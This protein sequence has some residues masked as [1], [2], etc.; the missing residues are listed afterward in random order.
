MK[1]FVDWLRDHVDFNLKIEELSHLLTMCGLNC[2]GIEEHGDDHVLELEVTS[3]RPDHLGHRGVARELSCLLKV[4]LKPLDLDFDTVEATASGLALDEVASIVVDDEERCGRYTARVAEGLKISES[5]DWIRRRLEAIGLRPINL[6][7]DLTNYVLMD[8]GQPLHA[9]DL[10][11]LEGGEVIVRR[12]QRMEKSSAIDGSEHELDSED[13]VIA[14]QSGTAALAG[15][16][17]GTRTE[18]HE[19]NQ[20]ILLESAWFEP[21]PVRLSSRRLI[22]ASDSSYRFERRLDVEACE[23]ASRRFMHL[24]GPGVGLFNPLWLP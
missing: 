5:P 15:I 1:V 9:F 6:V 8:L 23:I 24:P 13:L 10:D 21:V 19:G 16:M 20:R 22:L 7:V 3:N 17:G 11:R 18:V 12:A 4:P 14:D 2:E